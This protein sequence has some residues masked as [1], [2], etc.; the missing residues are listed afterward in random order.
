VFV[1]LPHQEK[2]MQHLSLE[3]SGMS[4]GHCVQ[5]V[6]NALNQ[7]AGVKVD[8]VEIGRANVLFDPSRTASDTVIRAV[9]D[10]GYDVQ[11]AVAD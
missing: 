5:A 7:V 4:C 3:I 2:P 10:A 8:S 6:T 9:S 11:L 1:G